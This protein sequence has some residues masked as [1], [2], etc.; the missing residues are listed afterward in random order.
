M[1]RGAAGKEDTASTKC[2]TGQSLRVTLPTFCS[3]LLF[4]KKL[5]VIIGHF[6]RPC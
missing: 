1:L 5:V 4:S 2:L 6:L 3:N